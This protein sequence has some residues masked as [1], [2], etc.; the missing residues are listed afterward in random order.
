MGPLWWQMDANYGVAAPYQL[1][2]LLPGAESTG[3]TP[4]SLRLS[5]RA[6]SNY[7]FGDGRVQILA[8]MDEV[9]P[10]ITGLGNQQQVPNIWR[11]L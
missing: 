1:P 2:A 10:A 4:W 11:G 8:P 7:L 9:N 3:L 5:H 6:K